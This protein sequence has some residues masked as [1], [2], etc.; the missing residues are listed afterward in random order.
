MEIGGIMP[1]K[2]TYKSGRNT[3]IT[4]PTREWAQEY[5]DQQRPGIKEHLAIKCTR[6]K[7]EK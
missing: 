7:V 2:V 5:I 3:I 6:E 4:L 1:F